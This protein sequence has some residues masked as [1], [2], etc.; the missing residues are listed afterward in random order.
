VTDKYVPTQSQ[1]AMLRRFGREC[2][3]KAEVPC[4]PE[5]FALVSDYFRRKRALEI[6]EA[7]VRQA[8]EKALG[9]IGGVAPEAI[10][11]KRRITTPK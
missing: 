11:E 8:K 4:T 10:T 7:R 2:K 5:I 3:L 9:E 6:A 1:A